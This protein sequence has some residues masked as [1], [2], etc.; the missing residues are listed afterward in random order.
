MILDASGRPI[1]SS[2]LR[3][4]Q[5]KGGWVEA[6]G[7]LSRPVTSV[8][9]V[10]GL[11]IS[12]DLERVAARTAFLTN[13]LIAGAVEVVHGFVLGTGLSYGEM[14][15][16][17]AYAQLEEFF[18]AN[19]LSE[20]ASRYFYQ[21]LV[22][23]EN[24]T[25]FPKRSGRERASRNEPARIGLYEV[26][27]QLILEPVPGLPHVIEQV[28]TEDDVIRDAGEFVW[29]AHHALW[30]DPRGWPVLMSAVPAALSY[31][32]FANARIRLH[33]FQSR[34]NAV[35][36]AFV[37]PGTSNEA[38][39]ELQRQKSAE[40][41]RIPKDGV[42]LTVLKN[43]ETGESEEF[44]FLTTD[45]KAADSKSDAQLLFR[46]F[47]AAVGLPEHFLGVT[48]EVTRTCYSSDTET[49]TIDG[50]RRYWE[51]DED[52]LI[53]QYNPDTEQA[54][55]VPAGPLYL[56]PYK[57]P[58]LHFKSSVV[59][60]MVTPD[61]RMWA[62]RARDNEESEA[63]E[64]VRAEEITANKWGLLNSA[65]LAGGLE[66]RTFTLPAVPTGTSRAIYPPVKIDGDLWLEFLGY[67][68][69]EGSANIT[70]G[71]YRV[72][73]AQKKP[74][75]VPKFR[76][77][78]EALSEFAFA[79]SQAP[80]GTY[81]WT[82]AD[83]GLCLWLM[84][85]CGVGARNMRLPAIARNLNRRQAAILF[86]ALMEG[87][88]TWERNKYR[89][90]GIYYSSSKQLVDDVQLLAMSLGHRA[91]VN[92]AS[93]RDTGCYR[94]QLTMDRS[95]SMVTAR[96]NIQQVDYDGE[97]YCFSVPTGLFITRRNGKIAIQGNTAE[98]MDAPAKNALE[99][100][101]A[102]V[103]EWLNEVMRLELKRRNGPDRRYQVVDRELKG[104][105]VVRRTRYVRADALY[106]PWSLPVIDRDSLEQVVKKVEVA[107]SRN[108]ASRQ[109]LQQLLGFDAAEE[110][111]RL[112]LEGDM[113]DEVD[114]AG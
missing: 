91:N 87:D 76:R 16:R 20:L 30:N 102:T 2:S 40:F 82:V 92:Y 66:L 29:Q 105:Q 100:H 55:W 62:K 14:A 63:Y 64:I 101:Q 83:K 73:L 6:S 77:V 7:D 88:G 61:H 81:R 93:M 111:E 35:Y 23:G 33:R 69:A 56:A 44:D 59:D 97:V 53:A 12:R 37:M 52:T 18:A 22:D 89:S 26:G 109:T 103:E 48:G 71:T 32:D 42:V 43:P 110:S 99:R 38:A 24:L 104:G 46:I 13:P 84:E 67:W 3:E 27:A 58:M 106:F 36:K 41:G 51:I 72:T 8:S 9:Q 49:L 57:G 28:M 60:I 68:I 95:E 65:P 108:L 1:Q 50:W 4:Q 54:E 75:T 47:A 5:I 94:V 85:N 70:S 107:A 80:D 25:L 90:C 78:V 21:W 15:D 34:L 19:R 74:E 39:K 113:G 98:S 96:K 114:D 10:L 86:D 79:E 112:A 17:R 11:P 31:I 45:T